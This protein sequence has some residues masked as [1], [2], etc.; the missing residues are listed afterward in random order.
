[1]R[2]FHKKFSIL[3][4]HVKSQQSV[5]ETAQA[6]GWGGVGWGGVGDKKPQQYRVKDQFST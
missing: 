1:M 6:M 5:P 2:G 3:E 4:Y